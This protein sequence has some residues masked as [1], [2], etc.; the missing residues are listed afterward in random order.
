VLWAGIVWTRL[1][2]LTLGGSVY[3]FS[4]I[5]AV[6]L[7]SVA[8]GSGIGSALSR[9]SG[10]PRRYF[11]FCQMALTAAVAWAAYAMTQSLPHWPIDPTLSVPP[12]F[13][14][15]LDLARCMWAIL[16]AAFFWGA[17]FPFA[18][19]DIASDRQDP[20]R[21]A[22]RVYGAHTAGSLAGTLA[23]TL[24]WTNSFSTQH[25]QQI[26]IA[27]SGVAALLTVRHIAARLAAVLLA[28]VFV[29]GV[30]AL[31]S[32][33]LAYGRFLSRNLALRDP[34][35]K[36][37]FAPNVL[38]ASEGVNA[39]VAV[40]ALPSGY[41]NLHVGGRIESSNQPHDLRLQRMVGHLSAL[42]HSSPKSVLAV[43][44]GSG[45]TVGTFTLY[46]G[47][48]RIV[49]CEIEPLIL[50]MGSRYFGADNYNVQRDP[51][52]EVVYDDARHFMLTTTEK[53]DIITS[54]P[55]LSWVKDAAALYTR[56]YFEI[57]KRHLN[58]GGVISQWLPLHETGVEVV[59]S[60]MATFFQVFPDGT[61]W[62][63]DIDNGV[64][65]DIM[66]MARN[67]EPTINMSE[68]YARLNRLDHRLVVESL[69][70]VGF[71]S[72]AELF[73]TYSGRGA[74]LV[75]WLAGAEINH[76]RN[77]RL[78]Y[79]AGLRLNYFQNRSIYDELLS[80]RRFPDGLF[81]GSDLVL[82]ALHDLIR[83]R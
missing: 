63:N 41:R 15:H 76:D 81:A 42:Y 6:L 16:P 66:L 27:L 36:E 34:E 32:D 31:P 5:L 29:F 82:Q 14:F 39:S 11:G 58:A 73:A 40:S 62:G 44:F 43:G 83:S 1:L 12:A 45:S 28:V 75:Q 23:L 18:L 37:A 72:V 70:S 51:R 3:A 79:L 61:I 26:M 9:S 8:I 38:Y 35:T 55:S 53:F 71:R 52:V 59:K 49:V 78:E 7:F 69:Q 4:I 67:G 54:H 30:P 50:Q 46:P 17:G 60:E 10:Q 47:I 74:D 57:G 22:G 25:A 77:L 13:S 21:V 80:H 19:A 56:E 64:G 24:V 65:Y 33:V 68:V 20:G 48:E 2:S